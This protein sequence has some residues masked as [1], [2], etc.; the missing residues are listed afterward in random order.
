MIICALSPFRCAIP[1]KPRP[2]PA[3]RPGATATLPDRGLALLV[4][5]TTDQGLVGWG[6]SLRLSRG[7]FPASSPS[8]SNSSRRSA[9]ARSA[10]RIERFDDADVQKKL[11]RLDASWGLAFAISAVDIAPLGIMRASAANT[12][13]ACRLLARA[14]RR[15]RPADAVSCA[16]Q[17]GDS[18]LSDAQVVS[19]AGD[20]GRAR[21]D[22]ALRGD[23]ALQPIRAARDEA[24]PDI[25]LTLDVN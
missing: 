10:A 17:P 14:C 23:R 16:V 15:Y 5:V 11:H 6:G 19:K 24:G 1:F 13:A 18:R 3:P 22:S 7:R 25:E 12:A 4:K 20:R 9:S 21:C 8:I 2:R